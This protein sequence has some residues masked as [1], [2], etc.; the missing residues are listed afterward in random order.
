MKADR[1]F[2]YLILS[3]NMKAD[4]TFKYLILS[5]GP[6]SAAKRAVQPPSV[7]PRRSPVNHFRAMRSLSRHEQR[8]SERHRDTTGRPADTAGSTNRTSC[9]FER[10]WKRTERVCG[11]RPSTDQKSEV[12][13][14]KQ[15]KDRQDWEDSH[16]SRSKKRY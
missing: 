8:P 16:H 10:E 5:V 4:R 1:T 12:T 15:R 3:V 13:S 14:G 11:R 7:H 6:R 9:T 2:K